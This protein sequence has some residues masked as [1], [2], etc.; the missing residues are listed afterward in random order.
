MRGMKLT[1]NARRSD[2]EVSSKNLSN[3]IYKGPITTSF[4][5]A[6]PSRK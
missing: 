4:F 1:S 6:N 2:S 3:A 5:H